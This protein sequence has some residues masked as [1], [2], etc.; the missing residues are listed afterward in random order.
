MQ[1]FWS[2]DS[3][4]VKHDVEGHAIAAALKRRG[5]LRRLRGLRPRRRAIDDDDAAAE[6]D[7][8]GD[9]FTTRARNVDVR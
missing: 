7:G 1:W 5:P 3:A 9:A 2:T 8:E 4:V 6:A